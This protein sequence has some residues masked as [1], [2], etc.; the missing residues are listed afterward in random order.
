M[1]TPMNALA[2]YR[3]NTVASAAAQS[4]A[5][6]GTPRLSV[7]PEVRSMRPVR[8]QM[9]PVSTKTSKIPMRAYSPG[10]S[11]L[12]EAWA[13]EDEPR[14]ASLEKI[15]RRIPQLMALVKPAPTVP[16]TA[17]PHPRAPLTICAITP[18]RASRWAATTASAPRT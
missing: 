12:A 3:P 1:L 16:P 14:P 11:A 9:T 17:G 5:P 2:A 6:P 10:S 15:P 8:V 4:A 7:T 18:G 13:M